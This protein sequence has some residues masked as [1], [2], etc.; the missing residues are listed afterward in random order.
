MLALPELPA[1][2]KAKTLSLELDV[3]EPFCLCYVITR[4]ILVSH[5]LH[6]GHRVPGKTWGQASVA[7]SLLSTWWSPPEC[8]Y[9]HAV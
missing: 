5:P 9:H 7:A 6:L 1:F 8:L 4:L 3:W 2:W